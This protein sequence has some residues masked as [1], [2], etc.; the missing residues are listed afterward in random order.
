M[1]FDKAVEDYLAVLIATKPGTARAWSSPLRR[2]A[3]PKRRRY[4]K[5]TTKEYPNEE[6]F[7]RALARQNRS[8]PGLG[9]KELDA[10]TPDDLVLVIQ[11]IKDEARSRVNGNGGNGAAENATSA[12]RVLFK[13]ARR[14]GKTTA[15]PDEYLKLTKIG[16]IERRAYT[17]QELEQVQAVFDRSR[18]PELARVFLRLALETGARHAEMLALT[19][20]D[21]DFGDGTV[22]LKP[23]GF[24]GKYLSA[25]ITAALMDA[26]ARLA[27]K[28]SHRKARSSTRV[29]VYRDGSPITRRYFEHL[30]EAVRLQIP[31]LGRNPKS[32]FSTHGLRH[33][34]GTIVQRAGGDAVARRFLGHALRGHMENYA[35][36]TEDEVRE[37]LVSIWNEPLAGQGHGFGVGEEYFMRLHA[38]IEARSSRLA[39]E[40]WLITG[41]NEEPDPEE[42]LIAERLDEQMRQTDTSARRRLGLKD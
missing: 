17:M 24:E 11:A 37:A 16:K 19:L 5:P 12:L 14:N 3:E 34:A 9:G 36:A 22:R 31:S 35:K 23:K 21:L 29:L 33:T 38:L 39:H 18:D 41:D 7:A 26:L 30:C 25:P 10:I 13:W 27:V 42:F 28:R 4:G 40:D 8:R 20:G 1:L 6:D 15:I 32:W 2:A